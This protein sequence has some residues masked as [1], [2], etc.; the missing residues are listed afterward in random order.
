MVERD[1]VDDLA[2]TVYEPAAGPPAFVAVHEDGAPEHRSIAA[3]GPAA[4]S[5][6]PVLLLSRPPCS[7]VPLE[8][9]DPIGSGV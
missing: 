4:L 1:E 5:R 9:P 3:E 8:H 6:E 2:V 7:S